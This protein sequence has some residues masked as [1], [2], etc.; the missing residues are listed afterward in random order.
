M[1]NE[2]L[3]LLSLGASPK[4]VMSCSTLLPCRVEE[5]RE[6]S[7]ASESNDCTWAEIVVLRTIIVIDSNDL[8]LY[9]AEEDAAA[10]SP[11]ARTRNK[12][13][14]AASHDAWT[15]R[16]ALPEDMAALGSKIP[17]DTAT[18]KMRQSQPLRPPSIK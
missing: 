14:C 13:R 1:P 9:D 8:P 4:A 6:A 3:E 16:E 11:H 12:S 2:M 5:Q 10:H 18:Q 7:V 17:D 15:A